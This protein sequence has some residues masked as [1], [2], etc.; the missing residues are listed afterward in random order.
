MRENLHLGGCIDRAVPRA[1]THPRPASGGA[2]RKRC[3]GP[4]RRAPLLREDRRSQRRAGPGSGRRAPVRSGPTEGTGSS[5]QIHR[6]SANR[7]SAPVPRM[8]PRAVSF[9]PPDRL[10]AV[11][12]RFPSFRSLKSCPECP[13]GHPAPDLGENSLQKIVQPSDPGDGPP[14]GPPPLFSER[15][16]FSKCNMS[17]SSQGEKKKQAKERK[18]KAVNISSS[19]ASTLLFTNYISEMILVVSGRGG[20]ELTNDFSNV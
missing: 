6:R 2:Y 10:F 19:S 1:A 5:Q 15:C 3:P 12:V 17:M 11:S 7:F 18:K 9:F 8:K 14:P 13:H 20:E 16:S 4:P